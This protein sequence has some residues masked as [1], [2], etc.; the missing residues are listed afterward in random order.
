MMQQPRTLQLEVLLALPYDTWRNTYTTLHL[1]THIVGKIRL[2]YYHIMAN[3]SW[4]ITLYLTVRGLNSLPI[5]YN[6][7]AFRLISI[8]SIRGWSYKP[9]TEPSDACRLSRSP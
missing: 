1:W 5:P 9:V 7:R 3:H 2:T 4:N 8:S 6:K